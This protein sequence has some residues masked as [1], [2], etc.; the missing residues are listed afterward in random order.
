[1][2]DLAAQPLRTGPE[3]LSMNPGEPPATADLELYDYQSDPQET[4]NLASEQPETLNRLWAILTQYPEA[5][6]PL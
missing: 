4:R 1:M 2:A 3:T 5:R 6:P